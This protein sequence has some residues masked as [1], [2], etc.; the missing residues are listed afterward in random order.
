MII[1]LLITTILLAVSGIANMY[2]ARLAKE[3]GKVWHDFSRSTIKKLEQERNSLEAMYDALQAEFDI[4]ETER[5]DIENE[6]YDLETERDSLQTTNE[7]LER[8]NQEWSEQIQ[9]IEQER[10]EW[11]LKAEELQAEVVEWRTDDDHTLSQ[12]ANRLDHAHAKSRAQ[13]EALRVLQSELQETKD[14]YQVALHDLRI[15]LSDKEEFRTEIGELKDLLEAE[16]AELERTRNMYENL[17]QWSQEQSKYCLELE[18]ERDEAQSEADEFRAD[19]NSEHEAH[20]ETIARLTKVNEKIERMRKSKRRLWRMYHRKE[21][22]IQELE[23]LLYVDYG[24]GHE[25]H[26][27]ADIAEV[28]DKKDP[29]FFAQ[30]YHDR[31]NRIEVQ[32]GTFGYFIVYKSSPHHAYCQFVNGPVRRIPASQ[33]TPALRKAQALA[34]R[35]IKGEEVMHAEQ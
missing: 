34:K 26:A 30:D 18:A 24:Y 8:E 20:G 10:D 13:V 19:L 25:A 9:M 31:P 28:L 27:I 12:M 6:R 7:D 33:M 3:N 4:L 21:G 29:H 16:R 22:I 2:Q 11:R 35:A 23:W 32:I 17:Q 15:A 1:L 5:D 14:N